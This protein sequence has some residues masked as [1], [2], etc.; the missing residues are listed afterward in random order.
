MAVFSKRTLNETIA[1]TGT[2]GMTG[3]VK[4]PRD[5]YIQKIEMRLSSNITDTGASG[6]NE[7]GI[8][9]L[10]KN[11]R[12]VAN[13]NDTR[14]QVY[15]YDAWLVDKYEYGT[16][17]TNDAIGSGA[18]TVNKYATICLDFSTDPR[19]P[20]DISALLPAQTFSSLWLYVDF[21]TRSDL[22]STV[23][24]SVINSAS[25]TVTLRECDL[26]ANDLAKVGRLY[27]IVES[28]TTKPVDA[29]YGNYQWSFDLPVGNIVKRVM[30]VVKDNATP[31][32]RSD[33]IL[34]AFMIKQQSPVKVELIQS[35]W[36]EHQACNKREYE[37]ETVIRGVNILNLAGMNLLETR[38]LKSGDIQ[39]LGI[40]TAV[41]SVRFITQEFSQ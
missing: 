27:K 10:L 40:T 23:G 14:V 20:L 24:T 30:V 36:N 7:D 29:V 16:P 4:I 8:L 32:I 2:G 41:G 25:I 34:G 12:L 1:L 33:A 22:W 9:A 37:A 21:G 13:G 11:L 39:F 28:T 6:D 17:N 35:A 5:R 26:D 31:S 18:G 38:G 3:S 19:N 15:G